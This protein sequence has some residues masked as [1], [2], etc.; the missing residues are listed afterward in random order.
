MGKNIPMNKFPSQLQL[1]EES[2]YEFKKWQQFFSNSSENKERNTAHVILWGQCYSSTQARKEWKGKS[3]KEY[4]PIFLMN[5]N[6]NVLNKMI[7]NTE[8][9]KKECETWKQGLIP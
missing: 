7:A 3:N 4:K 9:Y 8:I 5:T 6:I 2:I 1:H